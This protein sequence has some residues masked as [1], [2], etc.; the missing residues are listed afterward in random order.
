MGTSSGALVALDP[1]SGR[2]TW[3][4]MVDQPIRFQP[5]VEHGWIY[6]GTASG[7]LVAVD[8]GRREL[9]GWPM[10]GRNPAHL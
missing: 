6:L 10:W 2:T 3:S 8:T 7:A 5:A 9:T 4:L 1:A